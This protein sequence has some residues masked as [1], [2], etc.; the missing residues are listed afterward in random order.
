LQNIKKS[1]VSVETLISFSDSLSLVSNESFEISTHTVLLKIKDLYNNLSHLI[2]PADMGRYY[3]VMYAFCMDLGLFEDAEQY[4]NL[5]A[6]HGHSF[7]TI[8][9]AFNA[10]MSYENFVQ[11]VYTNSPQNISSNIQLPHHQ[12]V[13]SLTN[14]QEA[15]D[16]IKEFIH[17]WENIHWKTSD[18]DEL[19][20]DF[21]NLV[22]A[23]NNNEAVNSLMLHQNHGRRKAKYGNRASR[24]EIRTLI[25]RAQKFLEN[26][27][28]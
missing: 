15:I 11:L 14:N 4:L 2:I 22:L 16:A 3:F 9:S 12:P 23:N 10:L 6:Q 8:L 19:I 20:K 5:S 1:I 7:A 18:R 27:T 17:K 24:F 28:I 25:I 21:R 26:L 13:M